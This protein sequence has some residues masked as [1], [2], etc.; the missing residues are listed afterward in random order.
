MPKTTYPFLTQP[1]PPHTALVI[2]AA[3]LFAALPMIFTLP[4]TVTLLFA[5]LL[6]LRG[7]LLQQKVGKLPAPVLAVLALMAGALVWLQLGTI[8]GREGGIAF[9]LLMITLKAF[10]SHARRDWNVL[11]LAM[12]FLIGSTVL[13]NQSLLIGLWLLLALWA[14]SLCFAVAGGLAGRDALR[15]SGGALL[16]TLPLA[17]VLFVSVPRMSEP[18]WR[19]PQPNGQQASTGLSDSMQPGSISNL[20]QSDE[21]VANVVFSDGLKIPPQQL[22]WRAVIMSHFDGARW[23]AVPDQQ[24]DTAPVA[25]DSRSAYQMII[26]DQ[27]GI[28][29]VLD[30]P[31]GAL[32]QG[33]AKRL[34]NIVRAESSR[35]GLRRLNLN[36]TLGDTLPHT[37]TQTE[38]RRYTQLP[39]GNP[40]TRRLAA[41]LARTARDERTFIRNALTHFG[42]GGFRY[43]L[44]P[45][46]LNGRNQIDDFLFQS[47][48]GFCEHYAQSFAVIMRAA[49]LPARIVTGYLGAEFNEQAGFW[50]IRS[51]D[52]HAWTEVWL[53]SEQIWLRVDP[54]AAVSASRT[55]QGINQALPQS[56][57]SLL[58]G[59]SAFG[60]WRDAGQFYWQQ[61]VVNF[62][63]NR[64]NSLFSLLGLGGFNLKTLLLF[65]P[66]A[67]GLALLPLWRWWQRNRDSDDLHDGFMLLKQAVL[68]DNDDTL[69]AVTTQELRHIMQV[70]GLKDDRIPSLLDRYDSLLYSG[71]PITRRD[72]RRWYRDARKAA[73]RYR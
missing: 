11:L 32:P 62:D 72:T 58:A 31:A 6:L 24:D 33:T 7:A 25:N 67:L 3:L 45:P 36:A 12:L 5:A 48:Q 16:M 55:E 50:Q 63:Q 44:Q 4:P 73:R 60:K 42:N 38:Y 30:Y 51:K 28:L 13:L 40:Q 49:G 46:R 35:E 69:A 61:W 39:E 47:K 10:E 65:L 15:Y 18:L 43:T 66:V 2:L 26:R 20:V 23:L 9:L 53:P 56:E 37:L 19:I 8:L 22:Y 29:P 17:A 54:T 59:N 34:G 27:N 68:G 57:Q 70:N 1:P 52:A 21:W 14:V 41:E 71:R 64:Q